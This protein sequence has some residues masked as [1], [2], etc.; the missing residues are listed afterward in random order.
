NTWSVGATKAPI[1]EVYR[2]AQARDGINE[3]HPEIL[4]RRISSQEAGE[5]DLSRSSS[6]LSSPSTAG[7]TPPPSNGKA[8]AT[9]SPTTLEG[10][11]FGPGGLGNGSGGGG[12]GCKKKSVAPAPPP[13]G[14]GEAGGGDDDD[15]SPA[16]ALRGVRKQF[17]LD[18][19]VNAGG[20]Q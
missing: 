19:N 6:V 15:A 12:G 13:V 5:L 9:S 11:L 10:L 8:T 18:M 14:G 7:V 3:M 16:P 20:A 4:N 2:K 17:S 1:S